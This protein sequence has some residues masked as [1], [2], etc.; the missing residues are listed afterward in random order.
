MDKYELYYKGEEFYSKNKFKKAIKYFKRAL[1]MDPEFTDALHMAGVCYERL[2]IYDIALNYYLKNISIDENYLYSQYGAGNMLYRLKRYNEAYNYF[3]KCVE[4]DKSFAIGFDSLGLTLEKLG[5]YSEAK[6]CVKRA[7]E[8][9]GKKEDFI[10]HMEN[11]GKYKGDIFKLHQEGFW[12]FK[13]KDYL[14]ALSKY[15]LVTLIDPENVE[16]WHMRGLQ[17]EYL[18]NYIEAK[19]NYE[20]AVSLDPTYAP[21][22]IGLGNI[23]LI[24]RNYNDALKCYEHSIKL[25]GESK[26]IR[27][28][29]SL[30]E[31]KIDSTINAK[32]K[33]FSIYLNFEPLDWT[34]FNI[35]MIEQYLR[36]LP[37]VEEI[38]YP[39]RNIEE[40][41]S[42]DIYENNDKVKELRKSEEDFVQFFKIIKEVL[43]TLEDLNNLED[44][45]KYKSSSA[46]TKG[47]NDSNWLIKNMD[48]IE[49]EDDDDE[50]W[51]DKDDD[52]EEWIDEDD[53]D[54]EWLD[55]DEDDEEW[56]DEDDDEEEWIDED[57]EEDEDEDEEDDE[58]KTNI[59]ND[60]ILKIIF[61][62]YN[63][64]QRE[65]KLEKNKEE[66]NEK[67]DDSYNEE[68]DDLNE[69]DI[70][71]KVTNSQY[72]RD[73]S[74][75]E[76]N[77]YQEKILEY[78]DH[79]IREFDLMIV[80]CSYGSSLSSTVK[81]QLLAAKG[82]GRPIIYIYD[83][84]KN[85]PFLFVIRD[86]ISYYGLASKKDTER[87]LKILTYKLK[88]KLKV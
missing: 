37:F 41:F 14:N 9:E 7:I 72:K 44:Q 64:K 16:G 42:E 77:P 59:D 4:L 25:S 78:F 22:W 87:F 32:H 20:R 70:T 56:I 68:E 66:Y 73:A 74:Y 27:N 88:N 76:R 83:E 35:E 80:F 67:D 13:E 23:N 45:P 33:K 75:Y 2:N 79:K 10:T 3:K 65:G 69:Q 84:K 19:Y 50:E 38:F 8:I 60:E 43:K 85:L 47:K 49:N 54:E 11:I 61:N 29:I 48:K 51:I 5:K 57:E 28:N 6:K 15:Q 30:I 31:R 86:A 39:S 21:S 18:Q 71:R 40:E 1:S 36:S 81:Q 55:E 63:K 53:D 34:L 24:L 62:G 52:D 12:H 82:A 17:H 46:L 26:L 58:D